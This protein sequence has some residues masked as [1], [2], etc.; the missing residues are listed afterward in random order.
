MSAEK[1]EELHNMLK[2]KLQKQNT[3]RE[4]QWEHKGKGE[5]KTPEETQTVTTNSSCVAPDPVFEP[6]LKV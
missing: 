5:H 3:N 1:F 6:D 2:E 4:R